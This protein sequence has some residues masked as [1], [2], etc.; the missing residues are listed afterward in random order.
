MADKAN[1]RVAKE[2]ELADIDESKESNYANEVKE[3]NEANEVNIAESNEVGVSSKLLLL[4][5]FSLTKYSAIFAEVKGSFE[6]YNNQLG[7]LKG[8][9]L[10]PCS[11]M[12]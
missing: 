2:A 1:A 5:P 10:S 12:I 9:C 7:G 6:I 3:A 11:L 4:P 8:G